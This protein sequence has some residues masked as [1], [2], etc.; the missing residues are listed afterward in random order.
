MLLIRYMEY[1]KRA[2]SV[3]RKGMDYARWLAIYGI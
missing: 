2:A 1:Q 3:G